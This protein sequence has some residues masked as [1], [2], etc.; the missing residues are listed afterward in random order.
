ML[1]L[2]NSSTRKAT[3]ARY[4][5]CMHENEHYYWF[6]GGRQTGV[7]VFFWHNIVYGFSKSFW[8]AILCTVYEATVPA[9]SSSGQ[10][11]D[12][13]VTNKR[14]REQHSRP[15]RCRQTRLHSRA[16][17]FGETVS[18]TFNSIRYP[19]KEHKIHHWTITYVSTA[20]RYFI[21]FCTKYSN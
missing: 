13:I 2:E 5:G 4:C 16:G 12:I 21:L 3:K 18:I 8:R 14:H 17:P 1:K 10:I 7:F 19:H 15:Y 11:N 6:H 20:Y 9:A